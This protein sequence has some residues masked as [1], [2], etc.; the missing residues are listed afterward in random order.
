MPGT[1]SGLRSDPAARLATL[2]RGRPEWRRWLALLSEIRR[3]LEGDP[4][5]PASLPTP[6]PVPP[7]PLLYGHTIQVDTG[8]A[9][10]LVHRLASAAAIRYRPDR[11]EVRRL[12]AAA[13]REDESELTDPAL[14][15]VARLAVIPVLLGYSRALQGRV[16]PAWRQGYCPVCGAWPT[17]AERRGL[18][19]SRWLRCGRCGAGW[20][21]E[22][23]WCSYCGERDH[24]Q[25]GSLV[26]EGA[27]DTLKVDTC[28]S[29][30][31]YL[32]SLAVL[33]GLPPF[34]LL[35]QDLETVE[36]DLVARER[37]YGRPAGVASHESRVTIEGL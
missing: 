22:P 3:E 18:D 33:Q 15:A 31:G 25:L 8:R 11:D 20:E 7:A 37:G 10:Q 5:L 12:L 30:R 21:V 23:L 35:L 6:D 17:L 28:E 4:W 9:E 26:V 19:R 13:I 27:G 2:Q 1:A 36:L 14:S 32:K 34:E 16:S 29:C 24:R